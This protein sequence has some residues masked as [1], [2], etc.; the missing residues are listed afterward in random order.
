MKGALFL[1]AGVVCVPTS[2]TTE[3]QLVSLANTLTMTPGTLT[4][5]V[6]RATGDLYVH[7]M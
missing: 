6:D 3:L 7:T 1:A 2:A 4:L 5:A